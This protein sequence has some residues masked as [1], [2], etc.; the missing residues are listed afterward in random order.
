MINK[1][2]LV[3][4]CLDFTTTDVNK[5]QVNIKFNDVENILRSNKYAYIYTID[6]DN[7]TVAIS[8]TNYN[9]IKFFDL[10]N[11]AR[12]L[13]DTLFNTL[14]GFSINI[15]DEVY[16][17]SKMGEVFIHIPHI[18]HRENISMQDIN[19]ITILAYNDLTYRLLYT[20]R[21]DTDNPSYDLRDCCINFDIESIID[22]HKI[23]KFYLAI[24]YI[25]GRR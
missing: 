20:N 14:Q 2:K 17:K 11:L 3:V 22:T 23:M 12:K 4:K 19:E 1:D 21:L 24:K 5:A 10:L 16:C 7:L 8:N 6:N 9:S 13:S 15:F 25:G 18:I